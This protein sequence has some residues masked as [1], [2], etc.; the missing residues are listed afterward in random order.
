MP[1]TVADQLV[2]DLRRA[3][4]R[5]V[6][7]V[8]GPGMG[9]ILDALR[10]SAGHPS[11]EV[12]WIAVRSDEEAGLAARAQASLTGKLAVCA[13]GAGAAWERLAT[14]LSAAPSPAGSVLAVQVSVTHESLFSASV[15]HS[16]R[17]SESFVS[18]RVVTKPKSCSVAFQ[19]SIRAA[20]GS[21]GVAA[22]TVPDAVALAD[23][24]E[25]SAAGDVRAAV[26]RPDPVDPDLET[27]SDAI[28]EAQRVLFIAG[29]GVAGNRDSI[30]SLAEAVQAPIGYT[31]PA[32]EWVGYDNPFDIGMVGPLGSG[33]VERAAEESE[34]VIIWGSDLPY[35]HELPSQVRVFQV[36][37][38][39]ETLGRTCP[40]EHGVVADVGQTARA[41]LGRIVTERSQVFVQAATAR[42]AEGGSRRGGEVSKSQAQAVPL[43]P[44]YAVSV[45]SNEAPHECVLVAD[46][47]MSLAWIARTW[48][49]NESRRFV[50]S[51]GSHRMGDALGHAIGASHAVP[52]R[53]V[54]AILGDGGVAMALSALMTI[55]QHGLPVTA[56]VLNN[57]SYGAA[58]YD[59]L[60]DGLPAHGTDTPPVDYAAISRAIGVPAVRVENP[61]DLPAAASK[62]MEQPGPALVDVV[63]DPLVLALPPALSAAQIRGLASA[64]GKE[65]LTGDAAEVVRTARANRR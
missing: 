44:E 36:D 40:I 42:Y 47:G 58:R 9:P 10:R 22:V 7:G 13:A 64:L 54:V 53:P 52:L 60:Q 25:V 59:M 12:R 38:H 2:E 65:I 39:A 49:W 1:H 61:K 15:R 57:S 21:R 23:C 16:V 33:V 43:H 28:N 50:T 14:G 27:L 30:L 62:A 8:P 46:A 18:T 19:H 29:A 6:F 20:L 63:T 45:I 35:F 34:V 31:L 56:F 17:H 55:A 41:L 26:V 11:G 5:E 4:V 32:S 3:G 24:P 48:T 37:T 51:M